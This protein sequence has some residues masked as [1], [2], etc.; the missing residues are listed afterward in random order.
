MQRMLLCCK[1]LLFGICNLAAM[2]AFKKAK[3]EK[4]I[5]HVYFWKVSY[6]MAFRHVYKSMCMRAK[7]FIYTNPGR[8]P[9]LPSPL[10]GSG[11][12]VPGPR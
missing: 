8:S 11:I 5:K 9:L 1:E 4:V 3:S 2:G 6:R 10:P 7:L 12:S